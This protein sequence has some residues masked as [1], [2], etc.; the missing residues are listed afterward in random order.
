MQMIKWK[1]VHLKRLPTVWFQQGD[2]LEKQTMEAVK[3]RGYQG[4]G[5]RRHELAEHRGF[6]GHWTYSAQSC[7]SISVYLSI[8]LS[9][10]YIVY[11]CLNP[12]NVP[13]QEWTLN[14][15]L[16]VMMLCYVGSRI[17]TNVPPECMM[18]SR[19]SWV[20]GRWEGMDRKYMRIPLSFAVNIKLL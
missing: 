20:M 5:G 3:I 18:H 6:L 12:E 19:G 8:S 15:R 2:V 11:I 14:Y 9:P 4:L 17:T 7:N 1:R 16:W 10:I 13:H